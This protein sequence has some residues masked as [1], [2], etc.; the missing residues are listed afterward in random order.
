MH[1]LMIDGERAKRKSQN[2]NP[3]LSQNLN[4]FHQHRQLISTKKHHLQV[5]LLY[6]KEIKLWLHN[7]NH[8]FKDNI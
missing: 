4:Q 6:K 1:K 8:A 3:N 2:Q 7:L 5:A